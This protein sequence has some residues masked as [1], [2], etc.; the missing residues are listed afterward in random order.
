MNLYSSE[1]KDV[2]ISD[3]EDKIS[4]L[5]S[6]IKQLGQEYSGTPHCFP[7]GKFTQL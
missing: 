1:L 5:T 3:P 7:V 4:I 6:K 2:T